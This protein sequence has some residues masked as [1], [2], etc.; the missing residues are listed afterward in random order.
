MEVIDNLLGKGRWKKPK[1]WGQFLISSPTRQAW[2]V[3]TGWHTDFGFLSPADS[4][5]G[6]LVF[7][8]LADVAPRSGGTAVL[9]GSHRLIRRFV[10]TQFR[11]FLSK[12]KRVR[13][14]FLRSDP[15][16]LALA[17]IDEQPN[18]VQRFM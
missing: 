5:F 8:F 4:V 16:L 1:N 10:E 14:A 17:S 3:P 12:M 7:S 11:E 6:V 15:W 13:K 9:A 18:R 2:T